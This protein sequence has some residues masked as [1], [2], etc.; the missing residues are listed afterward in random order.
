MSSLGGFDSLNLSGP[1][2]SKKNKGVD[3]LFG[4]SRG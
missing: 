1:G 3:G 4:S 2:V